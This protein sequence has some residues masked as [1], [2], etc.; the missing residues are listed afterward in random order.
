MSNDSVI[1]QCKNMS[2]KRNSSLHVPHSQYFHWPS[3]RF[4][5]CKQKL[6]AGSDSPP[7]VSYAELLSFRAYKCVILAST[8]HLPVPCSSREAVEDRDDPC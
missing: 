3:Y 8:P 7:S 1:L 2:M 5:V 4:V 6:Y